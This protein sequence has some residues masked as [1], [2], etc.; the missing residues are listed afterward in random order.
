MV[1]V[2]DFFF[3]LLLNVFGYVAVRRS[4][5]FALDN[6]GIVF[7]FYPKHYRKIP[8]WLKKHYDLDRYELPVFLI[9]HAYLGVL[10]LAYIPLYLI[11]GIVTRGRAVAFLLFVTLCMFAVASLLILVCVPIYTIT[12]KR[13]AKKVKPQSTETKKGK[14]KGEAFSSNN[15]D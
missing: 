1:S 9:I 12:K 11:I 13:E 14:K 15:Q 10:L 2:R 5:K 7:R 6:I 8:K 3:F 4:L